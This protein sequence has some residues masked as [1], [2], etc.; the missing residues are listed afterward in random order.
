MLPKEVY[1]H[2]Q[3]LFAKG[4]SYL[5]LDSSRGQRLVRVIEP[6]DSKRVDLWL[7]LCLTSRDESNWHLYQSY[8]DDGS[9]LPPKALPPKAERFLDE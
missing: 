6:N 2:Y 8:S 7:A 4:G 1:Q 5:E 9:L 3:G